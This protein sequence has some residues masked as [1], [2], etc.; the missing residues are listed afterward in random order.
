[1]QIVSSLKDFNALSQQLTLSIDHIIDAWIGNK[2]RIGVIMPV[3]SPCD[4]KFL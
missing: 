1:M 4:E 2:S 3:E